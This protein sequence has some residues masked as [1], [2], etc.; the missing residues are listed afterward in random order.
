AEAI[1]K[2]LNINADTMGV[3]VELVRQ[4]FTP[5]GQ[6]SVVAG[7]Y[8]NVTSTGLLLPDSLAS[9]TRDEF[10]ESTPVMTYLANA[11]ETLDADG[12]V[13]ASIPY[14]TISGIDD[15]DS[16]P[17]NFQLPPNIAT[18]N[19]E[20]AADETGTSQ[21]AV[22][23]LVLN[24]WAAR[25][26]KVAKG[27]QVRIAFF[28]P[29]ETEGREVER[30]FAAVVTDIVPLVKPRRKFS[31]RRAALFD[32]R[33][34]PYND[35]G[36]TPTVP[37]VTDTESISDWDLPFEQQRKTTL[38][39]DEYFDSYRLT[40]KAFIPLA[41]GQRLFGSRFGKTTN[42]RIPISPSALPM[43]ST[44]QQDRD[45]LESIVARLDARLEQVA[46]DVGFVV[47]PIRAQQIAASAGTTPF[48]ALF[49]SLS[50]FVIFAA[51]L[52]IALLLGLALAARS[53]QFGILIASG[54]T[55]S[56]VQRLA[57]TEGMMIA[58][59]GLVIG[60]FGGIG[61]ARFV[62]WALRTFWVGA[63]TVPFLD[64]HWS[65]FSL[66]IGGMIGLG[67]AFATTWWTTRP[68]RST[69]PIRLLRGY[70]SPD[71]VLGER[72]VPPIWRRPATYAVVAVC[73]API[74]MACGWFAT[75]QQQSGAFVGGGMLLLM[76]AVIA[77]YAWMNGMGSNVQSRD[78]S[79]PA[80][81]NASSSL[82]RLA[83]ASTARS[84]L[85]SA[86]AVG[87]MAVACFLIVSIG[88]FRLSPTNA[89]TGGF[90]LMGQSASP[91]YR[92]LQDTNVRES[93][94]GDLAFDAAMQQTKITALR[95]HV[96]QDA[97]CNN[98]YRALRPTVYGIPASMTDGRV[99]D[100]FAW[101][102]TSHGQ[103]QQSNPWSALQDDADGTTE[104][105]IPM[106]LDQ[107]TALWSLQMYGGLGQTIAFDYGDGPVHFRVVGLLDNS[108]L[109]GRLMVSE[110]N[111]SRIFPNTS[112][113]QTFL[114]RT[115][116]PKQV[117]S[118]LEGRLGDVGMD[119]SDTN[120][121]LQRMMA[122]QNTYLRTFQSLG[123]LGLLLGTVG[124]AIAQ[125]RSVLQRQ[126]ELAVM[127]AIGFARSRLAAM[128][129]LEN[130]TLLTLGIGCGVLAAVLSVLP[131]LL[132][133]RATP[134]ILEPLVI[135]G[136]IFCVG[137]AGGLIAARRVLRLPLLATLRG[138]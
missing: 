96:G 38:R 45:F 109:Q 99:E 23:P 82:I 8:V 110:K 80:N 18:S 31:R 33:P 103:D 88:A 47:R 67:I 20:E 34:S 121:M 133:G 136:V 5:D 15:S 27:D 116:S 37:G 127:R 87:L 3:Q 72:R 12:T 137:S 46:P 78:P 112:G 44:D 132:M 102:A 24:D 2:S 73:L 90:S 81:A 28:E 51:V 64:F 49:L 36:L 59:A 61:Y 11:I 22:L 119:V 7:R 32:Q 114:I 53:S 41:D 120:I 95:T 52:L 98:L 124:L 39:D 68:L 89:G 66:L 29:E 54:W 56:L 10:P 93:L 86:L 122:V 26:L 14:S 6:Q 100:E 70:L 43:D 84:P 1:Q 135:V 58:G 138:Q 105:P 62:L 25:E 13:T 63:V 77:I 123:A 21:N 104:N 107:N 131:Y 106:V 40:P 16:L 85:N 19:P 9:A 91:I 92:D 65:W 4:T 83:A 108:V 74:V 129:L 126:R 94:L 50:F 75:G 130:S 42:L 71:H 48:D 101:I 118:I 113:Y 128:V 55:P 57:L 134:P 69:P 76:G 35:P 17:L 117:S 30:Y 125:L 111:F 60:V 115:N 79:D 97:S